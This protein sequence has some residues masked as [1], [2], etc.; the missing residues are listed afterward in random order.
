MSHA[1]HAGVTRRIVVLVS[2]NGSN[3]QA[4]LDA[5]LRGVEIVL[6]VSNRKAAFALERARQ[7]GVASAY[8]PLKPVLDAG[9]TRDDY[10]QT[11]GQ[12]IL[13]KQPDVIVLA[14]WMHVL[15]APFITRLAGIPI[16]N[17]HP[18]LPGQFDGT[19]SIER[20]FRAW[21]R[22]EI[23]HSG[24]MVHHVIPAVDAGPVVEACVVPFRPGDT[25]ESFEARLHEAEH[26][27]IVSAV[28]QVLGLAQAGRHDSLR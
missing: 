27:L 12:L 24:C 7:A 9:G 11:L 22:G 20:A 1:S 19:Q 16:I 18:A 6:V 28:R 26:A 23:M 4:L 14:G 21:E 5:H 3:L 10:E 17:L 15:G 25:L 8:L 13:D 2:G